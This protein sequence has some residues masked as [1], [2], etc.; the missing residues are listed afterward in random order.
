MSRL[1]FPSAATLVALLACA[2]TAA[3]DATEHYTIDPEHTFPSFEADHMGISIW[4]GK[5]N[6]SSGKVTLDKATDTGAV[7]GGTVDVTID[8][9]SVDFGHDKLNGYAKGPELFDIAK[10]PQ[11]TYH[12]TLAGFE[13][14]RPT[15]LVGE[16][17]LHGVTRPVEL[18]ITLFNC[19][20]HPMLKREQCG[21]DA[22]GTIERDDFGIDAGKD[23][24]FDMTV[25]LRIQVEA[26]HDA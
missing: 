22:Y 8:L 1:K 3:L 17:T 4:R 14:G 26:L 16:L 2:P 5:F 11:A 24:G 6:T 21:A 9:A 18:D 10:Y 7:T 15:R 19:V 12:G 25:T 20:P 13:D 23:Y